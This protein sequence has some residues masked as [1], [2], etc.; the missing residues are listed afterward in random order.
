[1]YLDFGS[2]GV[3]S[4]NSL[5]FLL[6][7]PNKDRSVKISVCKMPEGKGFEILLGLNGATEIEIEANSKVSGVV[8]WSPVANTTAREVVK[9]NLLKENGMSPLQITL[10]GKA[11]TGKSEDKPK[12]KLDRKAL[13]ALAPRDFATKPKAPKVEEKTVVSGNSFENQWANKQI[14][15]F[16]AWMNITFHNANM[17]SVELSTFSEQKY[18]NAESV[19]TSGLKTL[20]RKRLEAQIRQRAVLAYHHQDTAVPLFQLGEEIESGNIIVRSD[21]DVHADLGLQRTLM[22]LLFSYELPY[23]KLGLEVVFGEVIPIKA[24]KENQEEVPYSSGDAKW[25]KA[26]KSFIE[27][28]MLSDASIKGKFP[29]HKLLFPEHQQELKAQLRAHL[30]KKFLALVLVV[31]KARM[32]RTVGMPSLFTAES[33]IKSSKGML[34]AF[35]M[36]FLGGQG[37]FARYLSNIK[38][39]VFF[40]QTF[41]DEFDYS[42]KAL[43]VD[44]RDGVRLTKLVELLTNTNDLSAQLRVPAGSLLQKLHNINL[45]LERA[46]G[47]TCELGIDAKG[48]IE[49]NREATLFL[50]WK[51]Q[52]KFSGQTFTDPALVLA[53]A[54][55]IRNDT[56]W[57]TPVYNEGDADNFAVQVPTKNSFGEVTY[58]FVGASGDK[59]SDGATE[60][61]V[62]QDALAEWCNA[63]ANMYG[64]AALDI[65]NSLAD[66]RVLCLLIHYYHPSILSLASIKKTFQNI[67]S[68]NKEEEVAITNSDMQRALDGERRNFV[69]LK[70]A[71]KIIGGIPLMLPHYDS[72]NIPEPKLMTVFL[73]YLFTRLVESSEQ[74]RAS[75]RIQRY[76]RKYALTHLSKRKGTHAPLRVKRTTSKYPVREFTD[77][78]GVTDVGCTVVMSVHSA[79]NMIKQLVRIFTARRV[80]TR[81][82]KKR[83]QEL[84]YQQ[85]EEQRWA[86]ISAKEQERWRIESEATLERENQLLLEE[87]KCF[88]QK[89]EEEEEL[90]QK[91]ARIEQDLIDMRI[92]R[93]EEEFQRK[94]DQVRKETADALR[95]EYM[96]KAERDL[97]N[98]SRALEE[99]AKQVLE[100]TAQEMAEKDRLLQAESQRRQELEEKLAELEEARYEAEENA[101]MIELRQQELEEQLAEHENMN[102]ELLEKLEMETHK[103]EDAIE[104]AKSI[105]EQ[106]ASL[107]Q[108][109]NEE[110]VVG[111]IRSQ[112]ARETESMALSNMELEA[113][114]QTEARARE[115]L[116][117]R[118]AAIEEKKL[119]FELAE[120]HR[121]TVK[122]QFEKLCQVSAM[123]VQEMWKCYAAKKHL[124]ASR[125]LAQKTQPL[126][127]GFLVR[128]T[129]NKLRAL[130]LAKMQKG[131]AQRIQKWYRECKL[132][133][134][135]K[136]SR[137]TA[138][139]ASICIQPA[140]HAKE[141]QALRFKEAAIVICRFFVGYRPLRRAQIMT[142]GFAR[143]AAFYRSV[144]VRWK[145]M[146]AMRE[147]YQRLKDTQMRAH[148]NIGAR[149]L[150]AITILQTVK[151]TGQVS[152][153]CKVLMGTTEVSLECCTMLTDANIS[154]ILFSTIR[155]CNRSSAHQE[156]LTYALKVLL[157]ISRRGKLAAMVAL[158]PLS[159]DILVDLMQMFRDKSSVFG[160]SCELLCRLCSSNKELKIMCNTA[161]CRK[162]LD[163]IAHII[164]RKHRLDTRVANIGSATPSKE[165]LAQ[166]TF[167]G[168]PKG[169]GS[170]LA[171]GNAYTGIKHLLFILSS[172]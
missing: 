129:I 131:S 25:K 12:H 116:E 4:F 79:A 105:M 66:G 36:E 48:I 7:N 37:N 56:C 65:T 68:E 168:T 31:D 115:V 60:V 24:G 69:N 167:V 41:V 88:A 146:G 170:F 70:N 33:E 162:R 85:L 158:V 137:R 43:Q 45:A 155:S 87:Q 80:Y 123:R 58:P 76:Y 14:Q 55:S 20:M 81:S 49:G 172:M 72:K 95:N 151:G 120:Q 154:Q 106:Q 3:N 35:C 64:I 8:T 77:S 78:V 152:A 2:V 29:K 119:A 47:S 1:M 73:G 82:L 138:L 62:Q 16:T 40:E 140:K 10:V 164:E 27:E 44:L 94:L 18:Q 28:N 39:E 54:E 135:L 159:A 93:E 127:R 132:R 86:E 111:V 147:I 150:E 171:E 75:I 110:N 26:L 51:L 122:L 74:L 128:N 130:V 90:V 153:A 136:A 125:C 15:N 63:V 13:V 169:K 52:Y 6:I 139:R 59:L 84:L 117:A 156:L 21:K 144:T 30:V 23:L 38:Y 9:L 22:E 19:H 61:D 141:K 165:L 32:D 133:N 71:C 143:F 121:Q 113:K 108:R 92:Q 107:Q 42:V 104:Q 100:E 163:G 96:S 149:T 126:V 118:L 103:R 83:H 11:G 148:E 91:Q 67:L 161:D 109:H 17:S 114:W 50:L 89:L 57:R 134:A 124:F 160:L 5:Q 112:H 53:E 99:T 102:E 145:C 46:F 142:H 157:N 34:S 166:E 98:H 101:R 97:E